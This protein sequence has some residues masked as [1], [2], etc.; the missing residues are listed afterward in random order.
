MLDE[1]TSG[2]DSLSALK[3]VKMLKKE[4]NRGRTILATIHCPS[5]ESFML[6]NRLL[7]LHD[8]NEIYQGPTNEVT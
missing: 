8:G 6:F 2:L 3:L 4:A 7:L 5:L 1:P